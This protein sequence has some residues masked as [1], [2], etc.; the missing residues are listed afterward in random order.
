[1]EYDRG[2]SFPFDFASIGILFEGIT[3][4]FFRISFNLNLNLR[5][6]VYILSI[7]HHMRFQLI[8]NR[9]GKCQFNHIY[10]E[11][12]FHLVQNQ[13]KKCQYDFFLSI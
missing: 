2:D 7:L 10:L 11:Y 12:D 8:Q 6:N 1:M 5:G 3:L 4:S 13:M 9:I